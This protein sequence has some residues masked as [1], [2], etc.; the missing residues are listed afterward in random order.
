MQQYLQK[1]EAKNHKNLTWNMMK[2]RRV[3][4]GSYVDNI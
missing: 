2:R 3:S 1:V 4:S